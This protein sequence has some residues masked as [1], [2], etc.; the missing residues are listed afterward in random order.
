MGDMEFALVNRDSFNTN[1][2]IRRWVDIDIDMEFRGFYCNGKL[3]ALS[4]YNYIVVFDELS[5]N[6]E[7][8]QKI[9]NQITEFFY[10]E[11]K[12]VLDEKGFKRYI[13]DF[14][15]TGKIRDKIY[16]I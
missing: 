2:I 12:P 5:S 8:Q 1:I 13:V 16:V 15:L 14:A 4:Q 9:C 3:N 7:F 10:N 6:N 11:V